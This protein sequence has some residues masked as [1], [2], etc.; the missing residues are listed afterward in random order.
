LQIVVAL[1]HGRALNG[2]LELKGDPPRIVDVQIAPKIARLREP[3]SA[4]WEEGEPEPVP[5]QALESERLERGA[6][7]RAI[8]QGLAAVGALLWLFSLMAPAVRPRAESLRSRQQREIARSDDAA[9]QRWRRGELTD[10]RVG[11]QGPTRAFAALLEAA[12]VETVTPGPR[13]PTP[14][15]QAL[16]APVQE[17]EEGCVTAPD[18]LDT[19]E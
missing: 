6:G 8:R 10:Y 15:P 4:D 19:L 17:A 2:Q 9:V 14:E 12:R 18:A 16:L 11:E 1:S 13:V 5:R 3:L 7:T